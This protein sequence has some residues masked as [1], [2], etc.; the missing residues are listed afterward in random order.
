MSV[1]VLS[2]W[3]FTMYLT[4]RKSM[5]ILKYAQISILLARYSNIFSVNKKLIPPTKLLKLNGC[6]H[7]CTFHMLGH[8]SFNLCVWTFSFNICNNLVIFYIEENRSLSHLQWHEYWTIKSM[9]QNWFFV[10]FFFDRKNLE[11]L[12]SEI[13]KLISSSFLW[14]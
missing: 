4:H 12:A 14:L 13:H 8:Y 11:I 2:T 1:A 9:V 3:H 5:R 7:S 6:Q 10:G